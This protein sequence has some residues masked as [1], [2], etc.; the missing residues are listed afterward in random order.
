MS[1]LSWVGASWQRA[2]ELAEADYESYRP[3]EKMIRTSAHLQT[4]PAKLPGQ[5]VNPIPASILPQPT[6]AS[7]K[8][9]HGGY[10]DANP[11]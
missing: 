8:P 3:K 6:S 4:D 9:T 1:S 5:I 10:P 2:L 7:Y 11:R